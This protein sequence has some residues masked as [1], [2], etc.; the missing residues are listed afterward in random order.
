LPA[1]TENSCGDGTDAQGDDDAPGLR[2]RG[3]PDHYEPALSGAVSCPPP[4]DAATP[5]GLTLH[6]EPP[7]LP[8][9]GPTVA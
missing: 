5:P 7:H 8:S 1:I 6:A 4:V 3:A 2:A 9:V